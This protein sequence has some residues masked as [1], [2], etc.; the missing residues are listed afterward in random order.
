MTEGDG[1]IAF[2]A[3]KQA[4]ES[5]WDDPLPLP[6]DGYNPFD[7]HTGIYRSDLNFEMYWDD[8]KKN[9]NA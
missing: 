1:S 2:Y 8:S 5:S 9:C 7:Y 4:I 6:M 3:D